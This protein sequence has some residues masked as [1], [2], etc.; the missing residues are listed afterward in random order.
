MI[1]VILN[2]VKDLEIRDNLGRT[3][4]HYAAWNGQKEVVEL[5]LANG[6][7]VEAKDNIGLTAFDMVVC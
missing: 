5:L 3:A 4:L 2:R 1:R 6:A 7:D